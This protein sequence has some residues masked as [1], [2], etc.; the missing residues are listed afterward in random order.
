M[1]FDVILEL[2][3]MHIWK[4]FSKTRNFE[5]SSKTIVF[6]MYSEGQYIDYSPKIHPKTVTNSASIKQYQK[7]ATKYDFWLIWES[8][9]RGFSFQNAQGNHAQLWH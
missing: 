1:I 6:I 2:K 7:V 9:F 5:H 8:L 3:S 4:S